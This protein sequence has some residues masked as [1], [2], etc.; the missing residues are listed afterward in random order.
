VIDTSVILC[1]IKLKNPTILASGILGISS[2]L[3]VNVA[4]AGAGA[5]TS[6][7]CGLLPRGGHPNPT[8]LEWEHGLIN[9]VGLS[10]PG[11]EEEIKELKK[12]KI[13]L[14]K[15]G[16]PLIASFFADKIDNFSLLAEKISE[17]EPDF[18]EVNISCPNTESDLG[19]MFAAEA[20]TAAAVVRVVK[21]RTKIP[22]V[23]KLSP[24]VTDIKEIAK[25][26]EGAGVDAI[27]AIN[28]VGPGMFIDIE[29]GKPI[30]ANRVGGL[31]GPAIRPIAIAK[32][33]EIY[34]V[35]KIPVIG[36]GGINSGK[37][38]IEMM[39][40]GAS[41]VGVGSAVYYRGI[42]VFTKINQEI[43]DFMKDHQFQKLSEF[44]GI[45]HKN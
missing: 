8:V 16:V 32:V 35:V 14:K 40:A 42:K 36:I 10:N 11:V 2:E 30:L 28:T 20:K 37:D 26:V 1:G 21:K 34:S 4:K 17:A 19:R 39:M 27:S 44:K 13:E 29:S 45:A 6:K 5:V 22:L 18:L 31:S 33:F 41:A 12:A 23:V 3:L 9:A 43:K 38:A 15:L 7:S 24:N 25:A